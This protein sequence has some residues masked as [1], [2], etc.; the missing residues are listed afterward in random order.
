MEAHGAKANVDHPVVRIAFECGDGAS[1]MGATGALK[2][3]GLL[4]IARSCIQ[5]VQ[6]RILTLGHQEQKAAI[7]E[8]QHD[9]IPGG[10]PRILEAETHAALQGGHHLVKFF[11]VHPH[12]V[13]LCVA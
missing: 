10:L 1:E 4:G 9:A 12:C 11:L 5:G 13:P 7:G 6:A 8:A 2:A 3:K